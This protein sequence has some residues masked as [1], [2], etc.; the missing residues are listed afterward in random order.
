MK[1]FR[2]FSILFLLSST[3]LSACAAETQAQPSPAMGSILSQDIENAF[4]WL[5]ANALMAKNVDWTAL[6]AEAAALKPDEH[7]RRYLPDPLQG[8]ARI[9]GR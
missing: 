3:L 9:K 8:S 7:K 1:I 2:F 5:Q 4:Q 6:R